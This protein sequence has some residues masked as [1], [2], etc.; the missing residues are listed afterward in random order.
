MV[1][2]APAAEAAVVAAAAA[3]TNRSARQ[4]GEPLESLETVLGPCVDEFLF[5]VVHA[6]P[7][8]RTVADVVIIR[9]L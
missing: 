6:V 9:R 3:A 4:T 2:A 8:L 1:V 5:Y 7:R